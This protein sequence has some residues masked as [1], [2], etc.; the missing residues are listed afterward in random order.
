MGF[1]ERLNRVLSLRYSWE[2]EKFSFT[3][4]SVLVVV[5]GTYIAHLTW[6]SGVHPMLLLTSLVVLSY[7]A[8]QLIY[9]YHARLTGFCL[10]RLLILAIIDIMVITFGVVW[11]S[12]LSQSFPMSFWIYFIVIIGN[13]LRYSPL[14]GLF[15]AATTLIT[16]EGALMFLK[17]TGVNIQIPPLSATSGLIG[18]VIVSLYVIYYSL[19]LSKDVFLDP[20]TRAKNR[21]FLFEQEKLG[22]KGYEGLLLVDL[23][24]FKSINDEYG[25]LVG[26]KALISVVN[27]LR[28]ILRGEDIIVR[29]GGDEFIILLPNANDVEFV[30]KR[31][32]DRFSNAYLKIDNKMIPLRLSIGGAKIDPNNLN[33]TFKKAD[34]DMYKDKLIQKGNSLTSYETA[35][36]NSSKAS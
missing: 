11:E 30:K 24:D 23:N 32:K 20:L 22:L 29:W 13:T 18:L 14:I 3:I 26:D 2:E 8:L 17:R 27:L 16:F 12:A 6:K 19:K 10:A 33:G 35:P 28:E 21:Y 9:L 31:I 34:E 4:R 7:I 25:H 1:I 5:F 15:L 36:S